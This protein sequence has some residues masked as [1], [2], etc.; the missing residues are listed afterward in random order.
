MEE[1]KVIE[2]QQLVEKAKEEQLVIV[3][4]AR[5]AVQSN[6]HKTLYPDM[7]QVIVKNVSDKTIKDMKIGSIAFDQNGYPVKIKPFWGI[8]EEYE[9]VGHAENVN[10]IAGGRFGDSQGWKLDESHGISKVLSC[11]QSVTFYDGTTWENPYY[12]YWI[13]EYKEKPLN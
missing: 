5:I 7:I 6:E 3:E 9:F 12:Q 8:S 4:N 2:E 11:V 10:I 13:K 1:Q